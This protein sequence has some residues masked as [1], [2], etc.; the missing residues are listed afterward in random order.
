VSLKYKTQD[1]SASLALF[2]QFSRYTSIF[3]GVQPQEFGRNLVNYQ[4]DEDKCHS[5]QGVTLQPET[6]KLVITK[7]VI[8]KLVMMAKNELLV[9]VLH[10]VCLPKYTA[11][12]YIL[13]LEQ[14][15]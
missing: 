10:A 15:D 5:E 12:S 2:L 14:R 6:T 9:A 13:K 3:Q 1:L 4:L 7:L 8:T 11:Q